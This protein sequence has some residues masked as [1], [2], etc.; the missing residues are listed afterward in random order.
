MGG[1]PHAGVQ[2][3]ERKLVTILFADLSGYTALSERLDPEEVY[4]FLRPAM[5][6]L[7]GIVRSFGGSVPQIQ[8]DGFMAVFGV[9]RAH[10]DDAERAVRAALA[11][12]DH[13]QTLNVDRVGLAFPEVHAGVNS[14]EV[15]VGPSDEA[16]GF[17]V[18]G[19]TVNTASRLADLARAG[20]I[21]VDEKTKVRTATAI[22][23]GDR[24]LRRAKG[25]AE[26]LATYQALGVA[27]TTAA[28][29]PT[30]TFVDREEF[31]AL[32]GR[33]LE[34]TEQEGRGRVVVVA[35]EP[36]IGKSRLAQELGH[37][38]PAERFFV[39]RCAPFGDRGRLS[40]LAQIVGSAIG[41]GGSRETA[42]IAI[43]RT[44][45]RIG[46][47]SGVSVATELRILLGAD[48]PVSQTRSD[49]D[50]VYAAR[51]VMEDA[52]RAGPIAAVL[53]D[54]QWAD[55][56]ILEL[57]ADAHRS[58]WE[59]PVLLLGL[60]REPLDALPATALPGLGLPAMRTL[61]EHLLGEPGS[62]ETVRVPLVRANG[63][64]LFLE[65]MV[66]ML[67][68]RGAVRH[69]DGGWRLEDAALIDEVPETIRLVIAARLDALPP[70]AK[71][72]LADA[73]V[74]G[75]ST[76]RGVLDEMSD[77]D[78]P[79]TVLRDLVERGLLHKHPRSSVAGTTEY[80][81]KHAL[82]RDVAYETLPRATRAERHL[83]VAA[84]LRATA[85]R[86]REP[87]EAIA[88]Q[89]ERA[90]E[91]SRR[92]TGPGPS[93]D[94]AALAAEY[95]TRRG[96]QVFAQQ[97]RAAEPIFRRALRILD[98]SG[99]SADPRVTARA[100][101]GLAE[102]L[103]E[104]GSHR[105]AIVQADRAR[106]AAERAGDGRLAA[107]ALL[108]LGRS[109]SDAGNLKRARTLL[110]DA[111]T[112]SE[113]EGDLRGQ[114]WALHRLSETWGWESFEREL[115]D[116]DAAY[117]SFARAR[118]RF[119][120]S[121]VA[122]DLAYILSVQGGKPFHRWFEQ[123]R[124]LAEDEGDLRSRALLLRTWGHYCYSAGRF[125]EAARVMAEC[126]P[127]AADAGERYAE[128][129]ALVVGA[130]A[131]SNIGE[132]DTA[133]ALS[134][135]AVAIGK[136]LGSVRI[137]AMARLAIARASI[138]RG[139]TGAASRAVGAARTAVRSRGLRVMHS[140]VA[141]TDAMMLL[142]RGAWSRV[143]RAARELG[144]A[145][146][147]VPMAL[148]EPVPA[149]IHGRAL[150]GLGRH[151]EAA[152]LLDGAYRSARRVGAEGT[153]ALAAAVR[154]QAKLRV[155]STREVPPTDGLDV[156]A[157]AIWAENEGIAALRRG[158]TAGALAAFDRAVEGWQSIGTT[159]WLARALALRG[160]AQQECGDRAR[161]AA[162]VGRARAVMD[163]LRIPR[164]ERDAIDRSSRD[165]V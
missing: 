154:A 39:G 139:E 13:V 74:C 146:D 95:L 55:R 43:D 130:L 19:D 31:L 150:L 67:V 163:Q 1:R 81:W 142:D 60:S 7:E 107:Q 33:E 159:A 97:A 79:G 80:G 111:R 141:E 62:A 153:L 145:L 46:R 108:A 129:D 2:A 127:L 138:R 147:V 160:R 135:E 83:Q 103:I 158:D 88:F 27:P 40:A 116:L 16:S 128:S 45:R 14:G 20:Q 72:L 96:E 110:R 41:A 117:R 99:R 122:N 87:V 49:R 63:N 113:R 8:G 85:Q 112:R 144:A 6:E 57:L 32:L 120:R 56:S 75:S 4:S 5:L 24:Q 52:T 98:A 10:E 18:V 132:L 105:E 126:R 48:D 155:G 109:E 70:D 119:G 90:W 54:L 114:G 26:P 77:V 102:V 92:R 38:L 157:S 61:A 69:A 68:E 9:P 3:G 86:G 161:A 133:L 12:R 131:C 35:G 73:S 71:R 22:R 136:E 84:W 34:L 134:N 53:D 42:R 137:P 66:G 82:I 25:K 29:A 30:G 151:A 50:V 149:L 104:M 106:R 91:L 37:S 47:T 28:A 44:S 140:D 100:C 15:M 11:C 51:L 94:V 23:Y 115:E 148:W 121:V 101:V 164:K 118:D 21:V 65:E 162:S 124:R 125:A 59:A 156:E 89:Y 123:A 17:T 58:P 78:R 64:A 165:P 36:G 93:D 143:D 152:G 76:W